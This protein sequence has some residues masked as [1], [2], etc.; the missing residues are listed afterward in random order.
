MSQLLI[1]DVQKTF[2]DSKVL[3]EK[4]LK[5]V[6]SYDSVI[7]LYDTV[8]KKSVE[9]YD[10]WDEMSKLYKDEEFEPMVIEKEFHFFRE[11][12]NKEYSRDFLVSLLQFMLAKGYNNSAELIACEEIDE[13]Y[14]RFG[15]VKKIDFNDTYVYFP[16][17]V[18]EIK[19]FVRDGVVLVGGERKNCLEE[20][21]ILLEVLGVEHSIDETLTYA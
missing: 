9:N 2:A 10:M 17:V 14:E 5:I 21:S 20:I 11:L 15:I 6:D 13:L 1:I 4:I 18:F 12:M 19:D 7:Y 3:E 8:H 16:S